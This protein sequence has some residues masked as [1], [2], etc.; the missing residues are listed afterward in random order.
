MAIPVYHILGF[1]SQFGYTGIPHFGVSLSVAGGGFVAG[2]LSGRLL[3]MYYGILP[4]ADF[5][6]DNGT[7]IKLINDRID[8]FYSNG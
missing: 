6:G 1:H 8:C 3:Q 4:N 7:I 2:A 5:I